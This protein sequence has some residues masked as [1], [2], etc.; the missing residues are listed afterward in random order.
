MRVRLALVGP[1]GCGKST[2]GSALAAHIGADFV[3][4]DAWIER[5]A[6]ESVANIFRTQG[7]NAFRRMEADALAALTDSIHGHALVC[8]TGGGI[9]T[10][11]E[12]RRQLADHWQVV[13]LAASVPTLAAR[14]RAEYRQRPLLEPH[15]DCLEA[16]IRELYEA[17]RPWYEEVSDV[18]V[19]VDGRDVAE[20]VEDIVR[21]MKTHNGNLE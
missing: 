12:C 19:R 1:M 16:R 2:V 18:C 8:A 13:Y 9:V 3:D 11:A 4:L 7:E 10:S 15:G 21:W 6:G 17:R 5:R 20:I 14:L